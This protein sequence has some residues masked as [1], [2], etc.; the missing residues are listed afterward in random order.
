MWPNI[1]FS[2]NNIYIPYNAMNLGSNEEETE[3]VIMVAF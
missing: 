1:F 2:W 3:A